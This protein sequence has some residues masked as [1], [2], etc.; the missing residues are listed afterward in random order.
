[1]NSVFMWRARIVR[2]CVLNKTATSIAALIICRCCRFPHLMSAQF[3]A[4]FS[5]VSFNRITVFF[6]LSVCCRLSSL[7][8]P[9]HRRVRVY[10]S[11]VYTSTFCHNKLLFRTLSKF[12]FFFTVFH[13]A[14]L[15]RPDFRSL[16]SMSQISLPPIKSKSTCTQA[17]LPNDGR[18]NVKPKF[19]RILF[20]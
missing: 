8:P 16:P 19:I 11:V 7:I 14:N 1:M 13:A 3:R 15:P 2:V 17:H 5:F 4:A 18:P 10:C 20:S 6:F 9:P 12:V